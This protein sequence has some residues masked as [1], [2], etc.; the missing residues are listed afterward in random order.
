MNEEH[1]HSCFTG[2][3]RKGNPCVECHK[4]DGMCFYPVSGQTYEEV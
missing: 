3:D 2:L 4:V 1:R